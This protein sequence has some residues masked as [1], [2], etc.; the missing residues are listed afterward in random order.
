MWEVGLILLVALIVLG[1]QQLVEVARTLGKLYRD[2]Q[3][4]TW[5][6]R[7]SIDLDSI[8]SLEPDQHKPAKEK[9][10]IAGTAGMDKELLP[11]PGEKSGPDFYADLL[12]AAEKGAEGTEAGAPESPETKE[13]G[14]ITQ[15]KAT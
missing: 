12:E 10:D 8:T 6:L 7:N 3:K 14:S 2:L 11:P 13:E 15:K 1:P 4:M 9:T 5:D